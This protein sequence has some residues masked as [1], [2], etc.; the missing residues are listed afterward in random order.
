KPGR[1]TEDEYDLVKNHTI[2]GYNLLNETVGISK[3]IA[4]GALQHHERE[5]GSGYPL[6][7]DSKK[8]HEF[9]KIIAVCDVYNA[10][11]TERVY[12]GKQSPF[13]VA[14]QIFRDSFCTLDPR[15]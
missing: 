4:F 13:L 3:N 11:T 8:I 7:L 15:I 14:E 10:M 2:F 5:D 1:L 12:K 9:A 6:G